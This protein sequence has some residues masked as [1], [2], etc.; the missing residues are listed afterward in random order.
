[1]VKQRADSGGVSR[2]L[3]TEIL[4]LLSGEDLRLSVDFYLQSKVD[5]LFTQ[6]W[7]LELCFE[8]VS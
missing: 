8:K 3:R 7:L 1:M 5:F 4:L 2:P 6:K